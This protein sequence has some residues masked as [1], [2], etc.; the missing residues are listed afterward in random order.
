L[1]TAIR[2]DVGGLTLTYDK[3]HVGWDHGMLFQERDR[4]RLRSDQIDYDWFAE[5]EE[6]PA[7]MEMAFSRPL[8]TVVPR[9]ELLDIG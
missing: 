8:Q 1:G 4:Q 3:N 6:D 9:I 2:L 7:P 5:H